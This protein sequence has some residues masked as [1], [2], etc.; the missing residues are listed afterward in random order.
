MRRDRMINIGHWYSKHEP[1]LPNPKDHVDSKWDSDERNMVINYLDS[2]E[3]DRRYRGSSSCRFCDCVNGST[4]LTDGTYIW[5][6]GLSHYL[7]EHKVRLSQEF[8]SHVNS[9]V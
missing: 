9:R 6:Q 5:P 4:S 3:V 2:G 8:I 7:R 1:D